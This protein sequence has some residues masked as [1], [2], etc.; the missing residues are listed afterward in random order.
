[1]EK[2]GDPAKDL[3][4][5]LNKIIKIFEQYIGRYP[6]QW[7]TFMPFWLDDKEEFTNT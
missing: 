1:M 6:T 5:N 2:T 4:T 7:Y 3:E